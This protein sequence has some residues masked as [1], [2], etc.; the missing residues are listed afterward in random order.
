METLS[1][2]SEQASD[3]TVQRCFVIAE[4]GVNHN[5]SLDLAIELIDA[6]AEAGADAVKFQTFSAESLCLPGAPKARY[7]AERTGQGDQFSMLK[8]LELPP[9]SYPTLL[10]RCKKAGIMFLSTAFDAD[11]VDMLVKIGMERIKIP[12]GE[13]TNTPLLAHMAAKKLPLILSTGMS[14]LDE[15]HLALEV[16]RDTFRQ[17][18]VTR[19][20]REMVTVLHCTS[21]Y[22]TSMV[23]VNLRAMQTLADA[24]GLPV[25]Y[26]D[27]TKGTLV[28]PV[29]VGLG[30]KVIEKHLTLD[31]GLAG[32]DHA[33]SVTPPELAQMIKDIR[34]VEMA[35]GDGE[36]N[37][38]DSELENRVLVRRSIVLRRRVSAGIRLSRDDLVFLRPGT[39]IAPSHVVEVIGRRVSRALPAGYVLRWED[40]EA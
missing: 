5:G 7:Q 13:I 19:P 31:R 4:A 14:S 32:P 34:A 11:S 2:T 29:A 1:E 10:D 23:D 28:A 9:D 20:L 26:S 16:I 37:P 8:A 33:A 12:S 18:G 22:P 27:H 25:G 39:G 38:R 21:S 17:K 30:A 24:T 35:L 3:T 6:A 40:L 36:K 15:V